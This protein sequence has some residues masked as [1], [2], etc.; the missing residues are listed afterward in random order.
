MV[1]DAQPTDANA[2]ATTDSSSQPVTPQ[3]V[4][5]APA[6]RNTGSLQKLMLVAFGALALA[7][8]TGSAVYRLGRGRR[9]RNDWLRERTD[10]Q[11][12]EHPHDPPWVAEPQHLHT[13]QTA[14]DLDELV[15]APASDYATPFEGE[16]S[17]ERVEKIEEFLAR[18]SRQ[19]QAELESTGRAERG[20]RAAS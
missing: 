13:S 17:D 6:E 5:A 8:L 9:R 4:A 11:S 3:Q 12:M 16:E 10:W 1:A 2:N 19:L 18:F 7:G 14:P 15:A 20:A